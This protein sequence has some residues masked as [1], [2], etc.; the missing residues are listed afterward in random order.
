MLAESDLP[1]CPEFADDTWEE[2]FMADLGPHTKTPITE[3]DS[4]SDM[5]KD[6]EDITE[7]EEPAPHVKIFHEAITCWED[8]HSFLEHRGYT[9]EATDLEDVQKFGLRLAAHQWDLNYQDL[10]DLF[11]LPTLE[12]CRLELKLGLLFKTIHNLYYVLEPRGGH[13]KVRAAHPLQHKLPLAHTNAY[14]YSFSLI[15]C[16]SLDNPCIT[17]SNFTAFMKHLGDS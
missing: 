9:S 4:D 8:V 3:S 15:P 2:E 16:R 14:H 12:E 17:S 7:N 6:Q 13:P 1:V 11:Q 10:L 5:D